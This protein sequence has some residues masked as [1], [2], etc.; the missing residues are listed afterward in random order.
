MKTELDDNSCLA[1]YAE[2]P[3][4]ALAL[5]HWWEQWQRKES[6]LRVHVVKSRD[7]TFAYDPKRH[8]M[9]KVEATP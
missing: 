4:E 9:Q 7:E 8:F 1:I 5:S 6:T 3:I 2:T